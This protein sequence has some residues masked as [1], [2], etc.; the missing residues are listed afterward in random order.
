MSN[1]DP[2]G[3]FVWH[4]LLSGDAA[5]ATAF[6]TKVV[7]WKSQPWEQDSSY[8]MWIAKNGPVGGIAKLDGTASPHWLAY[9]AVPD[10]GATAEAAKGLGGRVLKD[11]TDLPNGGSYAVLAD[12]QG[13]QFAVYQAGGESGGNG[14]AAPGAGEFSWHELSTTDARAAMEFYTKLLGWEV[15]PVHD[16]GAPAGNY[17]LF[18]HEG[19]QY[20]GIFVSDGAG[21]GPSWLCYISVEDVG[22][23]TT[24]A[25]SAGGRVMNG[26]M[27]VPGGSWVAQVLDAEGAQFAV[28]EPA[29]SAKPAAKPEKAAKAPKPKAEKAAAAPAAA[30]AAEA[31]TPAAKPAA[32]PAKPA[33]APAAAAKP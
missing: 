13:A 31:T 6:Y 4:E 26:P 10:I 27:E 1:A 15:G 25:K 8:S 18:L 5:A 16:M 21:T 32:K 29:K 30:K 3:K 9:V 33:A 19:N 11:K 24:A 12:P 14:A 17:H 7:P 28:H 2:R 23:A 20:G 22:K